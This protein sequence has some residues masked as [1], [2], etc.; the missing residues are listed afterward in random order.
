MPPVVAAVASGIAG[1]IAGGISLITGVGSVALF[2]IIKSVV[3]YAIYAS[4]A[5]A[6][7]RS[8]TK[9]PKFDEFALDPGQIFI[10][11]DSTVTS[12][13]IVYGKRRVG[14][15]IIVRTT[16]S[17]G[18][19]SAGNEVTGNNKF[20]H[21]AIVVAGHEIES[22]EKIYFDDKLLT[23]NGDGFVTNE[24][25]TAE[26]LYYARVITHLGADNQ[27]VDPKMLDE[28]TGWKTSC[29]LK[30][31]AYIYVRLQYNADIFNSIPNITCVIKGAKVLDTRS[32]LTVWSDNPALCLRDYM[33]K[34][35]GLNVP[36]DEFDD[37]YTDNAANICDE[38]VLL[39]NGNYESR[40]TC[41]LVLDTAITVIQNMQAI[42]ACMGAPVPTYSQGT[43][44]IHAAAYDTPTVYIDESWLAGSISVVARP[45][46]KDV[47][48]A[49]RGVYIDA[50]QLYTVTDFTPV[51]NA[52]YEAQDNGERLYQ[53]INLA[54][55]VG[56]ERAQ[57]IGK[58]ILEKGRQGIIVQIPMNLKALQLCVWDTV[59]LTNRLLGWDDKVF[60]ILEWQLE[61]NG[62]GV[63]CIMQEESS[64]SYDWNNGEATVIDP[65]PDTNLPSAFNV[66]PPGTP[67]GV[68]SLYV[69]LN[70]AGVKVKIDFSWAPS[71]DAFIAY[72]Q[73]EYKLSDDIE[74]VALPLTKE[75]S[76]TLFDF[77]PGKYNIRVRAINTINSKSNYSENIIDVIGLTAPPSD[78]TNFSLNPINN[79]AHLSW[80]LSPDL[81]VR[82][83]GRV[84]VKHTTNVSSPSW[85]SAVQ[86]L[87]ALA[88]TMTHAVAPLIDGVYMI[89]FEDS[90]GV[91]SIN[92]ATILSTVANI[93]KMNYVLDAPQEPNFD[94][95]KTNMVTNDG[96]LSLDGAILFDDVPGLF[97]DAPGLFDA[98][99][100]AGFAT[101]GEYEF[102]NTIDIGVV[103]T[104]RITA[105]ISAL[106]YDATDLFDFREGL[107]DDAPGL[108]D[109][110]GLSG[111]YVDIYVRY[112]TDDPSGSPAWSEWRKFIVGDYT[113]RAYQFKVIAVTG[114]SAYNVDISALNVTVDVPDIVDGGISTTNT[115]A[116]TDV[117]F[118]LTFYNAPVVGVIIH[119]GQSGDVLEIV[120]VTSTNFSY[121]IKN[122]GSRVERVVNWIAKGF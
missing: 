70:G 114:N 21:I 6:L 71:P 83:G 7:S 53:D 48:N 103:I 45:S 74:Y 35:Y 115:S 97:D 61:N 113:A 44:R 59:Y 41:D 94:G 57:R 116:D 110:E 108:F 9:K 104:A 72:Y 49:V 82:I 36:N 118:N 8:F 16:E 19:D 75:T 32:D 122:E 52:T 12:H 73:F 117:Y 89:K 77:A 102:D 120:N 90:S 92:A 28:I 3:T 64:A 99:G 13:K 17:K 67:T 38:Q 96:I 18:K 79:N 50:D 121:N 62:L 39:K 119:N 30:G 85:S 68:E 81:D 80:D 31:L 66:T 112:T 51:T 95:I 34:S 60:R 88:G 23:I 84:L 107:F 5:S 33:S 105:T 91:Q 20:L 26:G 40:Y 87:P 43:F 101:Q 56:Q 111:A 58:I 42:A 63:S 55:V 25:F 24:E 100:G 15:Q 93:V 37:D 106:M 109:G 22:F 78:V 65:A 11:S 98:G 47:F 4:A 54:G 27:T 10:N 2:G 14:G 69:T 29:E 46:R 76:L 86:I 1:F